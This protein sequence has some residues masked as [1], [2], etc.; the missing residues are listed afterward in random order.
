MTVAILAAM[1]WFPGL[2]RAQVM[3]HVRV[4]ADVEQV[5]ERLTDSARRERA[6][7]RRA[8]LREGIRELRVDRLPDGR[9]RRCYELAE[10]RRV[11]RITSEDVA[12]TE[13]TI[14]VVH[15]MDLAGRRLLPVRLVITER[16]WAEPAEDGADISVLALGQMAGPRRVLQLLGYRD[17]ITA[18]RLTDQSGR[19]AE[20]T[21]AA[22]AALFAAPP[23]QPPA[24]TAPG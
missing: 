2:R 14:E 16:V 15:R 6:W 9:L 17:M 21:A 8:G 11:W 22:I 5:M 20:A 1:T 4:T 18:R 13:A 23:A 12:I 7:L 24:R 3:R 10:G 19:H